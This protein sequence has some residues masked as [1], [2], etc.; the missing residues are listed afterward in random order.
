[1]H[2]PPKKS[3]CHKLRIVPKKSKQTAKSTTLRRV[4]DEACMLMN[5]TPILAFNLLVL[6]SSVENEA[7]SWP[8]GISPCARKWLLTDWHLP[9]SWRWLTSTLLYNAKKKNIYTSRVVLVHYYF[10][11]YVYVMER[12]IY[13]IQNTRKKKYHT[14]RLTLSSTGSKSS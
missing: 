4:W 7:L 6:P 1:M 8:A 9:T 13:I 2:S 11:Y 12:N 10:N 5:G 14:E 3:T